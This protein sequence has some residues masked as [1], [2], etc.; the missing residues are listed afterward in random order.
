[1][2]NLISIAT[3]VVSLSF[4]SLA[5]AAEGGGCHFHGNLPAKETI[6][7]DCANKQKA[8]LIKKGK[9]DASWNSVALEKAEK[10]DGKESKEWKLSFKNPAVADKSKETL[11]MFFTLSG[12]FIA[13]NYSGK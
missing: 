3:F 7:V 4:T 2:K 6:V 5:M 9:L 10:I 13:A 12:N 11:Y 1:M 8:T